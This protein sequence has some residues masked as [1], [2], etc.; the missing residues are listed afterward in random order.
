MIRSTVI[1]LLIVLTFPL[2]ALG[3]PHPLPDVIAEVQ[4]KMVVEINPRDIATRNKL[5]MVY[6]RMNKLQEAENQF[7]EV[8]KQAPSDF[9]AHNGMGLVKIRQ[10]DYSAA[11][12]WIQKAIALSD[13]DIAVRYNLGFVYEQTGHYR[14]AETAY[15]KALAVNDKNI[16]NG[17][18]QIVVGWRQ[19][20]EIALKGLNNKLNMMEPQ[21]KGSKGF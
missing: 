5:G 2:P 12:P 8:L 1:L 17:A 10:R 6:V 14:E 15:R 7:A 16:G 11:L 3:H 9:D 13:S 21:S 4:Y 19:T 18:N 20:I